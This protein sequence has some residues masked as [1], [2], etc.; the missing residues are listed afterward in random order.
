[1]KNQVR[2]IV[3][4]IAG[5]VALGASIV[6]TANRGASASNFIVIATGAFLLIWGFAVIGR[7]SRQ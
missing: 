4:A 1:M 2:G 5:I 7:E 3:M 6:E